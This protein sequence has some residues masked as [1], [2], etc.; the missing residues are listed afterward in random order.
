LNRRWIGID[1]TNLAITLIRHRLLDAYGEAIKDTY[2][3]IGESVF[4]RDA[5]ALAAEDP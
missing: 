1:I 2:Q 4:L 5:E 3:V